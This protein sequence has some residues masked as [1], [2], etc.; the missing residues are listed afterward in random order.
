MCGNI[1][2]EIIFTI[3][4]GGL[5]MKIGDKVFVFDDTVRQYHDDQGNKTVGC[6]YKAKFVL[7]EITGETKQSYILDG[8]SKVKKKEIGK[9]IFATQEDVDKHIWVHE[10]YYKI[11]EWV[12]GIKD[13]DKLKQIEAI[14][15]S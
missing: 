11:G 13:Y 2:I 14:L 7:K 9:I 3:C 8:Y 15:N 12:K 4:E 5:H 1:V 6:Y 10:N